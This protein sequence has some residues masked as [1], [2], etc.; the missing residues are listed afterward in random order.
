MT[1]DR[2]TWRDLA[3]AIGISVGMV[4]VPFGI[5]WC[6]N[7]RDQERHEALRERLRQATI[8]ECEELVR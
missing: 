4:G 1:Y 6:V 3:I 2:S 7:Q 5:A 8:S